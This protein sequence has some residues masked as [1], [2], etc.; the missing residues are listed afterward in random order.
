MSRFSA[1]SVKI[2]GSSSDDMLEKA[3][4][5]LEIEFNKSD[6]RKMEVRAYLP[7]LRSFHLALCLMLI[8]LQVIGQ[9]NLGFILAKLGDDLF[10]IDQVLSW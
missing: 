8:G 10:I 7:N 3:T 4:K 2:S 5:E 1:A 6:F 9:F